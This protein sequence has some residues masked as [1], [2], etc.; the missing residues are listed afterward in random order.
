MSFFENK[1]GFSSVR[2]MNLYEWLDMAAGQHTEFKVVLPMIQRG[3][4]WKPNQIIE[5]WDSLLQGMP[6][7]TLMVSEMLKDANFADLRKSISD[8]GAN[9]HKKIGLVDGQQRTLAMLTGWVPF[10]SGESSHRLWVDFGDEPPAGECVR[11]RMTT[12]NQPFGYRRDNPNS[13]L[14]LDD[15]RRARQR[16][17]QCKEP[18]KE[19]QQQKDVKNQAME[20]FENGMP[21]PAGAKLSLPVDFSELLALWRRPPMDFKTKVEES[22]HKIEYVE[23]KGD[24]AE[25][26]SVHPWQD[27]SET[28]KDQVRRH[29]DRLAEGF[30]KLMQAEI[31]LLKVE[32]AFFELDKS[33]GA[34]PPLARLFKRIGSNATPLSDADYVYSILKHLMPDVH[35]MVERLHGQQ[36]DGQ[37]NVAALLTPTDLVMSALRLAAI[38]WNVTDLV[39]PNK[40]DF[41]RMIWPKKSQEIEDPLAETEKRKEILKHLMDTEMKSYFELVNAYLQFN[42]S[43]DCDIGLPRHIFPYL[44]TPLVQVLLRLAHSGYLTMPVNTERR[45]DVVRLALYWLQWVN[46][47]AKASKIA[48][49]VIMEQ[50][51]SLSEQEQALGGMIYQ[52]LVREGVGLPLQTPEAIRSLGFHDSVIANPKKPLVGHSRFHT[53]PDES[54]ANR[55]VRE[56]YRRWWRP[57][58]C[59]HPMLLWCQREYVDHLPGD[60][61]AGMEEDTPYDFD[62]ILPQSHWSGWTGALRG[63]RFLD[64][65]NSTEES[66]YEVIG[67]ALG[68]V[69]VWGSSGNRSDG[70]ASPESKRPTAGDAAD[71]WMKDSVIVDSDWPFWK[72]C[73]PADESM[74]KVWDPDRALAFQQAVEHRTF[75]LYERLYQDAGFECWLGSNAEKA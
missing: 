20:Q 67:N 61:M 69:R 39:K 21:Y 63:T 19:E 31:P 29:I 57:W 11:L 62:H 64:C 25:K 53:K 44:G 23:C 50:Q 68:N 54:E 74:K 46:D 16:F 13:K 65:F 70:D 30:A 36:H 37:H 58:T 40:D 41:H 75:D 43:H 55:L 8:E 1:S 42:G 33:V 5:L 56:F 52:A 27:L 26:L 14:T 73:S 3:F 38:N 51:N 47:P 71:K 34:E 2:V 24:P 72:S 7:G 45:A 60:P 12:K 32:P 18:K 15:K 9:E 66:Q 48:F 59:H 49:K 22:L 6:I 17:Y 10:K 28:G 35:E 4:V